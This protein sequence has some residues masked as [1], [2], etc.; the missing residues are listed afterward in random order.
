MVRSLAP[1]FVLICSLIF[2][3]PSCVLAEEPAPAEPP[4][5]AREIMQKLDQLE[6]Q[7]KQIL[8][9]LQTL[10]EELYIVKIRATRA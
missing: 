6:K 9:E 3:A 7:Q 1:V 2:P 4:A 10:K 8:Q 5:Y